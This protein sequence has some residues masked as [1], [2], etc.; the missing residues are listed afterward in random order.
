MRYYR[1]IQTQ[2]NY[3]YLAL[4]NLHRK[5]QNR[6]FIKNATATDVRRTDQVLGKNFPI[7]KGKTIRK[8]GNPIKVEYVPKHQLSQ[9]T[10][11]SDIIFVNKTI[12]IPI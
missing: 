9:Q 10:F 1:N 2:L 7:V 4:W 5:Y 3:F 12:T 11:N 6:T 8:K